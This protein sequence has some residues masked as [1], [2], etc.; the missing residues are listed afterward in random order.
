M[1]DVYIIG[2]SCTAFGKQPERSFKDLT[3]QAYL[4]VL[5]DAGLADGGRIEQAWFGNC[6]MGTFGRS[7]CR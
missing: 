6:G 1:Q 5:A 7:G 3:R 2:V 4:D